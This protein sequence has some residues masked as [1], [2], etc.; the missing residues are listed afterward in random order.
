MRHD[1]IPKHLTGKTLYDFLVK[2]EG[3]IFHA[4]KSQI[5]KADEAHCAPMFVND[6]GE[7]MTKAEVDETQIDPTKLRV[8]VVI[9][10]TNWYDSHGDVH[11]PGLWKKSLSDNK[12]TGFYLLDNHQRGFADVIAEGCQAEAKAM[13]WKDVGVNLIGTTEALVFAG[14]IEQARNEYMFG[15]YQK[16]YVKKHSVGMR[17][18]KMVTCIN[19]DDYPVQKEN[20]DK[21]INMVANQADAEE[22][23]YF[24]AILEAQVI[25]GSAVLFASNTV[26]PTLET[27]L[28]GT[29][30]EP[31]EATQDEPP[32]KFDLMKAIKS[33]VI[34]PNCHTMFNASETGSSSCSNCGQ[35]TSPNSTAVET[36][37]FNLMDAIAETKFI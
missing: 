26:T 14:I 36:S 33:I 37:I 16:K 12:K 15:Q 10:T 11:I 2:N 19:D 7:L 8:V 1:I 17:Y 20:W 34:C 30:N 28:L 21:Y 4:K 25:E 35:Y 31:A 3:L 24:W 27:E 9:N 18:V 5:K 29:K 32:P 23:G 13:S 6:K 22:D